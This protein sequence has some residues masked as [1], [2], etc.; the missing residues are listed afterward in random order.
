MPKLFYFSPSLVPSRNA[1]AVH[2]IK[3]CH[4][5]SVLGTEVKL[6]CK[7]NKENTS[8]EI[9]NYYGISP[10]KFEII[11][12]D[13]TGYSRI[14]ELFYVLN[15][16]VKILR[17]NPDYILTRHN[18]VIPFISILGSQK[19][20]IVELHAPPN[21][22]I[23]LFLKRYINK[24]LIHQIIVISDALKR[25]TLD[26]L[27]N[28][29]SSLFNVL[30]DGADPF[31]NEYIATEAKRNLSV[32][33]AG[34]LYK[35]RG[36]E[37]I[38]ELAK[39]FKSVD[40][41]VYGGNDKDV[42]DYKTKCSGI[43]NLFF[44]GFV[45]PGKVNQELVRSDFLIAP[46]QSKVLL[47]NGMDTSDYMSPL[48]IF[49]YMAL[50]K[51]IIC[52]KLPVLEEV[53]VDGYNAILCGASDIEEWKR[54]LSYLLDNPDYARYISLNAKKDLEEKYSWYSRAKKILSFNES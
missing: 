43:K 31:N 47:S 9:A 28:Q 40:F 41:N 8:S 51:P 35:G 16:V 46:Y 11:G 53:L 23:A 19:K 30:H 42:I 25:L 48:K 36:I 15:G 27:N 24:G 45:E 18:W 17:T 3:I 54:A 6:Y 1:N 4:Q 22:L 26:S 50:G 7:T 10:L 13:W 34:H 32:S 29:G 5:F 33:Y 21:G 2:V 12:Y 39:Y 20:V 38:I 14:K 52:S 49:E 37:V 44:H